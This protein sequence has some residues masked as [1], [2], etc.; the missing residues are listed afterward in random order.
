[1]SDFQKIIS[2]IKF[3]YHNLTVL[4]S[5]KIFLTDSHRTTSVICIVPELRKKN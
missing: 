3:E 4:Y 1:M 2:W 5:Q